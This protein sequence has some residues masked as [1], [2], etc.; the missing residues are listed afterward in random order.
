ML[1]VT[2]TYNHAV[3]LRLHREKI[4]VEITGPC[5]EKGRT[6]HLDLVVVLDTSSSMSRGHKLHDMKQ[7]AEF[8]IRKMGEGD[9]LTIVPFSSEARTPSATAYMSPTAKQHASSFVRALRADGNTNIK[10]GIDAA[11]RIL[12]GRRDNIGRAAGVFLM[13]DGRQHIGNARE[14]HVR[15]L[16]V[17]TFGFGKDHDHQLLY[18]IAH[19]SHGGTYHN[20]PHSSDCNK[21]L[22]YFA[23][24]LGILR[25]VSVL[26]LAVTLSPHA[27]ATILEVRPGNHRVTTGHHGSSTIHF[28]ELARKE[29]R[30]IIVA[31][32]LPEVHHSERA[33]VVMD[34][35]CSYR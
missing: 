5:T 12:R 28:G 7:A 16:P 32:Q 11:V 31:I 8:V 24:V 10:D 4:M 3:P 19:E 2:A 30:K 23:K 25:D 9:R 18:D 20:T 34:V 33:K 1:G 27:G 26:N 14:V 21:L 13:S 17:F 15:D 35:E 29:Q 22:R 6:A